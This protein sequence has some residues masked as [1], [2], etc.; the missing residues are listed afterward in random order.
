MEQA[1]TVILTLT[2]EEITE[3]LYNKVKES[4]KS[5]LSLPKNDSDKNLFSLKEDL[6]ITSEMVQAEIATLCKFLIKKSS[7][8]GG[9]ARSGNKFNYLKY[10]RSPI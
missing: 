1:E 10:L 5:E 2:M 4:F 6:Y 3:D 9:L 7:D 8:D